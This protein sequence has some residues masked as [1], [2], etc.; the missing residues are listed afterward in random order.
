M[1]VF[2]DSAHAFIKGPFDVERSEDGPLAN[3]TFAVKDVFDV[4]GYRTGAGNPTWLEHAPTAIANAAAID[5]LLHSG[6]L[7][8]GSTITD[9]LA[10]SLSGTNVHYGTPLNSRAPG[11]IPGGSSAG[12]AAA[13]A[14]GTVDFA[15][16]TDTAG[17]TRVPASYCGIWGIRPSHG[18]VSMSGVVPLAP[19]FDTVGVLAASGSLLGPVLGSLLGE[20]YQPNSR[21]ITGLIAAGDL[22]ELADPPVRA[23]L[24]VAIQKLSEILGLSVH[25]RELMGKEA[26]EEYGEGFRQ[27]QMAE[28]WQTHG[29]WIERYKPHFGPGI[30]ARFEFAA[31]AHPPPDF[32]L[33]RLRDAVQSV[34]RNAISPGCLMV[35]PAT[36]SPAPA[37]A[38]L[39]DAKERLRRKIIGLNSIAGV[40]GSPELVC[41]F[42]TSGGLPIGL[43]IMGLPGDDEL[44]CSIAEAVYVYGA[45]SSNPADDCV[46]SRWG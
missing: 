34:L 19:S 16:G 35:L 29:Q 5:S 12:S 6:A 14:A 28:V 36:P 42:Q 15:L 10:F 33:S 4:R 45:G 11:H 39:P 9:E 26:I 44:L 30:A 46:Q 24:E 21:R 31:K 18:R 43:G 37:L 23:D 41:P 27:Q 2:A 7:L 17:S 38:E 40:S 1:K 20:G 8:V 13:V 22:F 25:W 3:V 32:R